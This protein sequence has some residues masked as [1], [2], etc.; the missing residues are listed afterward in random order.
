MEII[1]DHDINITSWI[2][3]TILNRSTRKLEQEIFDDSN[4]TILIKVYY[5]HNN[6]TAARNIRNDQFATRALP[7]EVTKFDG[8]TSGFVCN[9]GCL[10]IDGCFSV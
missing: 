3:P 1:I 7:N 8:E 4:N 9:L 2:N 10:M 6:Q 5:C